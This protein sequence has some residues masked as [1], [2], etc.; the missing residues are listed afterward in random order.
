MENQCQLCRTDLIDATAEGSPISGNLCGN[1]RERLQHSNSIPM[2]EFLDQFAAPILVVDGNV[3]IH[4]ANQSAAVLLRKSPKELADKLG[5]EAIECTHA[6]E[7]E[8]CGRT[9][10][11]QSCSIRNCVNTTFLTGDACIDVPAYPDVEFGEEAQ[12]L[13]ISITTERHGKFVLLRISK[14]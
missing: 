7:P 2:Q 3:R 8:G 4:S 1:C 6:R 5:G 14:R 11:C 9:I 12:T 13:S 10:H